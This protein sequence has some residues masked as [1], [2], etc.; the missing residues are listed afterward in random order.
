M[1]PRVEEIAEDALCSLITLCTDARNLSPGVLANVGRIEGRFGDSVAFKS[2]GAETV[3]VIACNFEDFGVSVRVLLLKKPSSGDCGL[4]S[5]ASS[6]SGV[7]ERPSSL[8][9]FSR[10]MAQ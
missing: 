1:P 3:E 9:L 8:K 10:G 6:R 7:M 5:Y 4:F 2:G